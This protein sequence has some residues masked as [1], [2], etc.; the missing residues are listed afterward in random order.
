MVGKNSQ[1]SVEA[2]EPVTGEMEALTGR[3]PPAEGA[4][5]TH[6]HLFL[7]QTDPAEAVDRARAA[8][9]STL[10]CVGI[11]PES[12]HRSFELAESFRGVF[13]TAGVHPHTATDLDH[14][15]GAAIEELLGNPQVV[16]VG[17]TGLD[18]FRMKSPQED[19][20]RAFRL[21][22]QWSR[23]TGKPLVVHIRDA[24]DAAMKILE[25]EEAERV[26]LHCFSGDA[27]RAA[28][29]AERGYFMSFAGNVTYPNAQMLRD[30]AAVVPAGL[31]LTET[32]SPFLTPQPH[33]GQDNAPENVRLVIEE[34]ARVRGEEAEAVLAATAR[35]AVSAFPGLK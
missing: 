33:R 30:A 23:D 10:L 19:Q 32:D 7:L 27:A 15:A 28:E 8:G 18:F 21:H 31:L 3:T 11:D 5:D 25:E 14:A 24:W 13:A 20:E 35:N 6:C 26:V 1:G 4:V 9:V 29:C 17:E 16:G 12:S 34:L 22:I 2:P